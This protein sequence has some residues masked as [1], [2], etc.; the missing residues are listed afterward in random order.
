M[1]L[2]GDYLTKQIIAY[3]GNKRK[4]LGLVLKAIEQTDLDVKPGLK[5]FDVFAGSGVVS[6]LAKMLN[7]EIFTNDWEYYSYVISNCYL[8]T[9]KKD[10]ETLFGSEEKFQELLDKINS[11]PSPDDD[12]Q[13]IANVG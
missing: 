9:N 5:F 13:Y 1:D 6:R 10:I 12:N 7:F 8:K 4:L 3:I 2:S 11:L